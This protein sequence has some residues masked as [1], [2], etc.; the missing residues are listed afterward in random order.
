MK[1]RVYSSLS[2]MEQLALIL[3]D[4]L[5]KRIPKC[6]STLPHLLRIPGIVFDSGSF[7]LIVKR[8]VVPY[9]SLVDS[10][11]LMRMIFLA[12]VY[13]SQNAAFLLLIWSPV[14]E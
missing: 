12:L 7:G 10:T 1:A 13:K 3:A 14:W 5:M 9:I 8:P 6:L 2:E 4:L 11:S